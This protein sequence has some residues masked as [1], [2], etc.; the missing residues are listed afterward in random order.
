MLWLG[1]W[2]APVSAQGKTPPEVSVDMGVLNSLGGSGSGSAHRIHL[3]PPRGGQKAKS[4]ARKSA[5]KRSNHSHRRT[6]RRHG[7]SSRTA[8]A[9]S[10]RNR[11]A[12]A[13]EPREPGPA[14]TEARRRH[15]ETKLR[16]DEI[17]PKTDLRVSPKSVAAAPNPPSADL[18]KR[19]LAPA[20]AVPPPP[21]ATAAAP[22]PPAK[23]GPLAAA[24]PSSPP[25]AVHAVPPAAQPAAIG[26]PR[27]ES[28]GH[29]AARV[30]FTAGTADLSPEARSALDAIAKSLADDAERRLQLVAYATGANEEANQARRLSL[31][32]ALNVRAYLIDHGVRNTRMDVRALGNRTDDG[33]PADRVDILFVDK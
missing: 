28:G 20:P 4:T 9:K 10:S 30:D 18:R 12:T 22:E 23:H 7:H 29:V 27:G 3:H 2:T 1:L 32:R 5:R 33:K 13:S 24:G 17:E 14:R 19:V 6:A 26:T 21:A 15:H 8:H 25:H 31:S 11:E 16:R